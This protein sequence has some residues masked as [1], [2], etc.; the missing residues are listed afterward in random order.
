MREA[1]W[2]SLLSTPSSG[3]FVEHGDAILVEHTRRDR[4]WGDGGM[5]RENML[6][7]ILIGVRTNSN[8]QRKPRRTP[9]RML[10]LELELW[11][12]TTAYWRCLR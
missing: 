3:D 6:G 4:Y 5:A 10:N 1:V 8:S 2:P 11:P 9:M 7:R 12:D